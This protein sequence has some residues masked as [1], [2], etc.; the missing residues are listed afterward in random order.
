MVVLGSLHS[1]LLL[2]AGL[3]LCVFL[4]LT[5][6]ALERAFR[7]SALAAAQDRLQAQIY[8]L[9]S[10]AELGEEDELELR[11]T[12]PDSRLTTPAS[13]SFAEIRGADGALVWRSPSS[14]G[15]TIDYPIPTSPGRAVFREVEVADGRDVLALSFAVAWEFEGGEVRN[16]TFLAAESTRTVAAEIA[17]FRRSLFGWFALAAV[18]LLVVQV[19]VLRWGLAPL[20]RL[21]REIAE[22]ESGAKETLVEDYPSEIRPLTRALNALIDHGR[23]RL[24]R[25]RNALDDLAHSLKTPLAVLRTSMESGVSADGLRETVGEQVDLMRKTV[26]YQLQRAGASGRNP[27]STPVNVAMTAN[28]I[29]ESLAKVY[30]DRRLEIGARIDS[31]L[32][33]NGDEGDLTEILGNLLDN[34]C[35]WARRRVLIEAGRGEGGEG[36]GGDVAA[37]GPGLWITVADDGPG[38]GESEVGSLLERGSRSQSPLGGQGIGLAVVKDLVLELY[39]GTLEIG[40]SEWGGAAIRLRL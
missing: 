39:H 18:A 15:V 12:L 17:R 13:G 34:A 30:A 7:E 40:R 33:F 22:I 10:A 3:V 21:A 11:G 38:F 6:Y 29:I 4:G 32:E 26:D 1:R 28:R 2:T 36:T 16:Y 8:V 14:L 24:R 37:R 31:N 9:L 35:K 25:Y 19:V 27:L 23:R 5:G 20:R